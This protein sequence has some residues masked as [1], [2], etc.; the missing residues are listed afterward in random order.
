MPTLGNARVGPREP[1]VLLDLL[2]FTVLPFD[3]GFGQQTEIIRRSLKDTHGPHTH[4]NYA[5]LRQAKKKE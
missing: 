1:H 2:T 4:D 3:L 5:L